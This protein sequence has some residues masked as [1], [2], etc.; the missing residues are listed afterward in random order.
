MTILKRLEFIKVY[1]SR[2]EEAG[3]P[4]GASPKARGKA[5]LK[6]RAA[7]K[8]KAVKV[9]VLQKK[10]GGKAGAKGGEK[11]AKAKPAPAKKKGKK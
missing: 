10:K 1:S 8:G 9:V 3:R 4:G 6:G 11:A 5:V 2:V 7:Q